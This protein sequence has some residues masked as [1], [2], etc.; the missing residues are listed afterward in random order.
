MSFAL[1][2]DDVEWGSLGLG[3]V[4]A[5]PGNA[6]RPAFLNMIR[7][8]FRFGKRA[9]EVLK[10]ENASTFEGMALGEYLARERYSVFFREN[11]VVPMCAAI[12]SC[13]DRD[14]MAFPVITL[15]RFWV[16]HHLLNVVERPLWRVVKGGAKR[17]WTPSSPLYPRGPRDFEPPSSPPSDWPKGA[18]SSRSRRGAPP[19]RR[20]RRR[21]RR[22][23][24]SSS[25]VTRI[26]R[27]RFWATR[28]NPRNSGARRDQIPA[29]RGVPSLGP[30][31]DAAREARVGVVEL[32]EGISRHVRRRRLGV[33]VVLGEPPSKSAGG[34]PGSVRDAQPSPPARGGHHPTPRHARASAV[35]PS[36][37]RRA[38]DHRGR[39][40]AR[41]VWFAGAWCGYGFHEDGIK[42]AVDVAERMFAGDP[43]RSKGNLTP[44][45]WD[46]RPC[47][48]HLSLSTK[49]CIPLFARVGWILGAARAVL[50]HDSSGRIRA[51]DAGEIAPGGGG[52]PRRGRGRKTPRGGSR[53]HRVRPEHVF[54]LGAPRGHRPRRELHGRTL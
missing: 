23:T 11:Y 42:S 14:T 12:W 54:A 8:V 1:S 50:P 34:R 13:S 35:Q 15:I 32:P 53:R 27:L 45:P 28:R 43:S 18:S 47:D 39:A 41:G 31:A 4:F 24:T 36:G 48:P 19:V 49:V 20:R 38:E 25:R 9:P 10:P 33:R 22:S 46:P 2:T 3:A 7:E 26:R 30:V 44:V 6:V 40:G 5:Q 37:H 52:V 17:T 21:S 16:N 29:Q 51:R